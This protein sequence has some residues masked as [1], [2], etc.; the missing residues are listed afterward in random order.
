MKRPAGERNGSREAVRMWSEPC[1][2]SKQERDLIL[3]Q[4]FASLG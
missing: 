3:V 1:S 2:I 4:V